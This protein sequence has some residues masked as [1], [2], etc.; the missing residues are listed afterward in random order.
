MKKSKVS[1]LILCALILALCLSACSALPVAAASVTALLPADA[2]EGEA[3]SPAMDADNQLN[4]IVSRLDEW[5]QTDGEIRWYYTVTDLDHDNSL[6]LIA[7]AQHPLDRSTNLKVWE[8]SDTRDSLVACAPAFEEDESFPDILTDNVDTYHN[9]VK[10]TWSYMFYDR[11]ILSD[12]E[13]YS[14]KSAVSMA[15]GVISYEPYALEHIEINSGVFTVSHLDTTGREI[16]PEQFN[17]AGNNAFAGDERSN[18]SFDYIPAEELSIS[19]LSDSYAVFIGEKDPPEVFPVPRPNVLLA[20]NTPAP[21]PVPSSQPV[22]TSPVKPTYLQITKNPTNE[23]KKVGGTAIFVACSNIYDSLRW[24]FVA[25]NGDEFDLAAFRAKFPACPV[26]GE[27]STSLHIGKVSA[28][29]SNWGAYCTFTYN[30][31]TARTSTAYVYVA[32]APVPP[33][34]QTGSF[35]ARVTDFTNTTVTMFVY[36]AQGYNTVVDR[37]ICEISGELNL[38]VTCTAFYNGI[39]VRGP[40]FTKVIIQGSAPQPDPGEKRGSFYASVA[41]YSY[42]TITLNVS[43]GPGYTS[44]V[45]RGICNITGDLYI[46]APCTAYYDGISVRGPI[47]YY[48]VIEGSTPEPKPDYSTMAGT[49]KQG[50]TAGGGYL[51]ELSD[52]S[53]VRVGGQY[54]P[55]VD[56]RIYDQ[57][58]DG[59][60]CTVY[61][62]GTPIAANIYKVE[63]FGFP[64]VTPSETEPEADPSSESAIEPAEEAAGEPEAPAADSEAVVE[65]DT[66]PEAA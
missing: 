17:A 60:P 57:Y 19:R 4:L 3:L 38:G 59:A 2:Q 34:Q 65:T 50:G 47:F 11:V 1:V 20:T 49:V 31:Q 56:I 39:S 41:D 32:G 46:G 6:E 12:T 37:S 18:T 53:E 51:I 24:T 15:D 36:D 21:S 42:A 25:P 48:V 7:A 10:D 44:V 54:T 58:V 9:T 40:I 33:G 27:N 66:S 43:D 5:R 55:D 26:T 62:T 35:K 45:D 23:N 22:P 16:T 63:I 13:M 29:L 8:V 30:G 28:D 14:V 52:L 64:V 61:Y